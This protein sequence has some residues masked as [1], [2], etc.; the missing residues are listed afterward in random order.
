MK[1]PVT[2]KDWRALWHY[3]SKLLG[4]MVEF[5]F[6]GRRIPM[7]KDLWK[8]IHRVKRIKARLDIEREVKDR[9]WCEALMEAIRRDW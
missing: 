7:S 4:W 1:R 6:D 9:S 8:Q 5:D 2:F 3:E